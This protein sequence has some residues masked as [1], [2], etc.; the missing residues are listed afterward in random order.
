MMT[1]ILT[2]VSLARHRCNKIFPLDRQ[3][4]SGNIMFRQSIPIITDLTDLTDL[5]DVSWSKDYATVTL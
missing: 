1:T 4:T 5:L 3:N 2:P